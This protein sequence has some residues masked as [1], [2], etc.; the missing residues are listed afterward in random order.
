MSQRAPRTTEPSASE[1]ESRERSEP[2]SQR[3]PR[4]TEPSAS[5]VES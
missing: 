2:M 1:V 4:T 3:A 5:E